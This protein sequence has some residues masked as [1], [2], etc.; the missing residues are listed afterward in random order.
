MKA[1]KCL[2]VLL[3]LLISTPLFAGTTGKIAGI[4]TDAQSGEKL[5]AAN[6]TVEG[7]STGA[8]TN[9]DGFYAIVNVP[10]GTYRVRA[11]LVGYTS[12]TQVEVRVELDQ[13]TTLNF[14]LAEE[15]VQG[16]EVVITAQRPV[17]QRDI[18]ASRANLEIAEVE[19]LPVTT[20]SSAISLQAGV[21]NTATGPV[22]R[23]STPD[24]A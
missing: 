18:S 12:V 2:P 16:Q 7:L 1:I 22:I 21:Q 23:G 11:S 4:V 15:S 9:V 8:A 13:T 24:Q 19:R 5:L 14:K 17:V 6:V 20:V 3:S 10:P